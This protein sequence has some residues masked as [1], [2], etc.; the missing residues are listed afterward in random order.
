MLHGSIDISTLADIRDVIID[1]SLP[2]EERKKS[3]I[4]QIKNPQ[5]C[6]C[7]DTIL[8]ISYGNSGIKMKDLLLQHF[9]SGQ[10]LFVPPENFARGQ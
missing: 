2:A 10:G 4:R 9:A 1:T 7:G 5:L 6:R 3:Y 8:R